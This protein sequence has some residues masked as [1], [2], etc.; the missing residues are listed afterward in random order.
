MEGKLDFGNVL[1]C[2]SLMDGK[3]AITITLTINC[4]CIYLLWFMSVYSF[5]YYLFHL[6]SS[7][8]PRLKE[9]ALC[10]TRTTSDLANFWIQ[11][12]YSLWTRNIYYL[13]IVEHWK[14]CSIGSRLAIVFG[15]LANENGKS[16]GHDEFEEAL[17]S[18]MPLRHSIWRSGANYECQHGI[19]TYFDESLKIEVIM[20]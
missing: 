16:V 2:L 17:T 1:S 4:D 15:W 14:W 9:F 20:R 3:R 6:L 8:L 18:L 13:V 10:S 19:N 12:C 11:F 5:L 7:L